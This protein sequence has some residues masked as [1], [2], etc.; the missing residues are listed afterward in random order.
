MVYKYK[1]TPLA[2][3]DINEAL[4]YI[5]NYLDNKIAAD[6]LYVSIQNEISAI[7]ENPFSFSECSYYLIEDNRIRHAIV[8]NYVLFYE[9]SEREKIIKVLRFLYGKRLISQDIIM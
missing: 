5:A 2:I 6:D 3:D 7:R 9:V 1:L 4:D 8:G